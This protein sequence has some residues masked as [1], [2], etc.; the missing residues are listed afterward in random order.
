MKE[1]KIV[2]SQITV[3]LIKKNILANP[4]VKCFLIDGFP[5]NM[6]QAGMFE[7]EVERREK[8]REGRESGQEREEEQENGERRTQ[9]RLRGNKKKKEEEEEE[10]E[11]RRRMEKTEDE[12]KKESDS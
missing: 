12:K 2:P 10:R 7:N 11:M 4:N 9:E 3:E 8:I 6:E 1:G 5:R